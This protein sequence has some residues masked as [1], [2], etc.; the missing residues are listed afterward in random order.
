VN[1][2]VSSIPTE[3][4]PEDPRELYISLVMLKAN[5]DG[6]DSSGWTP[7]QLQAVINENLTVG[8]AVERLSGAKPPADNGRA[9]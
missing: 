1:A 8:R 2:T 6:I 5:L 4:L 3:P 9:R 7:E